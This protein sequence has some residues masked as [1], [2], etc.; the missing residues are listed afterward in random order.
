MA[1]TLGIG[2][3]GS[4]FMGR[5]HTNAYSSVAGIFEIPF[6]PQLKVL[7][8]A[9]PDL[10][11][12][13]ARAL[14][15]ERGTSDWIDLVRDESVELV[16]IT[17]PNHLHHPI[18][19]A[20]MAE[21]KP[22]YCEKP[23]ACTLEEA[24]EMCDTAEK[25]GIPTLVG[26]NYLQNP[27]MKTAKSIL[28]SGEIGE[29]V[30]FR[31][32]HAED[33]MADPKAPYSTR[34]DASQG[35]G[36][37]YD[38]GSHIISLARYLVGSIDQIFAM[39]TTVHSIRPKHPGSESMESVSVDDQTHSLVQFENGCRGSLEASWVAW[40]RKMHLSF[41]LNCS[42]GTLVFNQE[43]FNELRLYEANQRP[44]RDGF[45]TL[46]SGPAHGDYAKF[47]PAPGHQIGF[48]E[49]KVIELVE[50]LK[51]IHGKTACWPDFR[52]AYEI[53]KILEAARRSSADSTWC[54]PAQ[55]EAS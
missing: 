42:K 49:L 26:Y 53:Q 46:E 39:Q 25:K 52:E 18:A 54:S 44:G 24:M 2:M 17:A 4:G 34:L 37:F 14:Q 12:A 55:M 33:Y 6:K 16:D 32:V 9:T 38:L 22:V 27:L 10:A 47:C 3:V 23:L 8:D 48:N 40:G 45:K 29:P 30:A 41:E 20:A 19:M 51:A 28:D 5:C 1:K 13:A 7:A 50:L 31:G 35:G 43:R 36:V 21:G 11:D 15:F